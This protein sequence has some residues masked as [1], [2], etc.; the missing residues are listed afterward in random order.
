MVRKGLS[1][2]IRKCQLCD[3]LGE[4]HPWQPNSW[5]KGP[6]MT[7]TMAQSKHLKKVKVVE[8]CGWKRGWSNMVRQGNRA[9]SRR[10]WKHQD[11]DFKSYSEYVR[12][13][14]RVVSK[15]VQCD[16]IYTN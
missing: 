6:E 7:M 13:H 16:L 4:E 2:A 1:E 9:K 15:L 12:S 14:W 10:C 5:E 11:K 8:E 3:I